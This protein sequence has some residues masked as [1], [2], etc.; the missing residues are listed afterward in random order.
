MKPGSLP[1]LDDARLGLAMHAS[2]AVATVG[3]L[4]LPWPSLG[5]RITLV[6]L[7]YH[8]AVVAVGSRTQCRGWLTAWAVLAPL[9]VLMVAPDWFLSDVL[10]TLVFPDTGAAFLGSVPVFMAGM[11]TMALLPLVLIGAASER[12]LGP[13]LAGAVVAVAGLLLFWAAELLAPV[14]PLWAPVDVTLVGG[15]A[16]YVL[17]AEVVLSVCAWLLV[18]GARRRPVGQTTAG[19]AALPFLY[20]GLLAF[21]YQVLG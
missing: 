18:R 6:V 8:L 7:G 11:W 2:V 3:V 17:P 5:V 16:R 14:V 4:A 19:V 9:S 10:G 20:L 12:A 1:G 15:V 13:R 21:G